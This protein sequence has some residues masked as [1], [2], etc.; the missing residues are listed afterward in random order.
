MCCNHKTP[1]LG[2]SETLSYIGTADGAAVIGSD[3]TTGERGFLVRLVN[4]TGKASV[5]G[6]LVSASGAADNEVILQSNTFDVVGVIAESGILEGSAMLVWRHGSL[7]Q[8]LMKDTIAA[9]H[10]YVALAS[11]VP[12]RANQVAVP[13]SNPVVAEHFKEIG[14]IA[15]TKTGGTDVL[16]LIHMHTL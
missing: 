3:A 9:T 8:V 16:V 5:K 14:H 10:G 6:E 12:G 1:G 2:S 15:E 11:D 7:C 4:R 13:S